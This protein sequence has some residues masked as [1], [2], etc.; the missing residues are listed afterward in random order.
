MRV[1]THLF[2]IRRGKHDGNA[3]AGRP[4][5]LKALGD[6]V[7]IA[8]GKRRGRG[9]GGGRGRRGCREIYLRLPF[10]RPYLPR[11][12][13]EH[14]GVWQERGKGGLVLWQAG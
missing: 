5:N 11:Q 9:G 12:R 3:F 8:R 14:C 13:T 1:L 2:Q 4:G 6:S 7:A 10:R